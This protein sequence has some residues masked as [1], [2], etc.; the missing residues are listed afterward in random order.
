[1]KSVICAGILASMMLIGGLRAQTGGG[2]GTAGTDFFG[3]LYGKP[4]DAVRIVTLE[5]SLSTLHE[6][7][8]IAGR[9][10]SGRASIEIRL[11]QATTAGPVFTATKATVRV[12]ITAATA[13]SEVVTAAHIHRGARGVN[14]PVVVDFGFT[15]PTN[16]GPGQ[17]ANLTTKFEVT[18]ATALA[19]L[20]EIV[21]EPGAFYANIHTQQHPGGHIRGQL[22][23]SSLAAAHRLEQRLASYAEKD[24]VD[25]KR[26]VVRLAAKEGLLTA[27][28][29][30]QLL[31]PLN[32]RP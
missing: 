21:N 31:E 15:T 14:G 7:P 23:E 28:E 30:Q 29:V 10:A 9:D 26:L 18:D 19:V 5:A 8:L 2:T 6:N 16:T 24:L 13:Q 3:G 4:G 17:A 25:I 27:E 12:N 11:D 32:N 1:M 20:N 22:A